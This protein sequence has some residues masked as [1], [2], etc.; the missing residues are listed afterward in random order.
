[1]LS[2][3]TFQALQARRQQ[4]FPA[5]VLALLGCLNNQPPG[6]LVISAVEHTAVT[7][8]AAQLN[9]LGWQVELWPVD[10]QGTHTYTV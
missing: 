7:A 5:D 8:A 2:E 3:V 1:M 10:H 9:A 6:R 4:I